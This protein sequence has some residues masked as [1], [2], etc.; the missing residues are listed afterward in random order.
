M[1]T[2]VGLDIIAKA[3]FMQS[4]FRLVAGRE[5]DLEIIWLFFEKE[6]PTC[7]CYHCHEKKKPTSSNWTKFL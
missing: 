5:I 4:E 3:L 2:T 6:L 7:F 1:G